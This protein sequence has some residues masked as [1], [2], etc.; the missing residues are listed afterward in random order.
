M[1]AEAG[2]AATAATV[3]LADLRAVTDDGHRRA[4][5]VAALAVLVF[6]QSVP[7]PPAA[8]LDRRPRRTTALSRPPATPEAWSA[9]LWGSFA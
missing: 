1:S 6:H 2:V 4:Q 5:T 7:P 8:V 9:G 3:R